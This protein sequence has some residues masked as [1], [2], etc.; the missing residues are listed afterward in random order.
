[1][2]QKL[3]THGLAGGTPL[4][5]P[6]IR[7]DERCGGTA[8]IHAGCAP[9]PCID[10]R[11]TR[12]GWP[13]PPPFGR[14]FPVRDGLSCATRKPPRAAGAFSSRRALGHSRLGAPRARAGRRG[15]GSQ[16]SCTHS[17]PSTMSV[18]PRALF[19]F[20]APCLQKKG[21]S[22]SEASCRG[23]RDSDRAFA[24]L[25]RSIC[26]RLARRVATLPSTPAAFRETAAAGAAARHTMLPPLPLRRLLHPPACCGAHG[27][28]AH[29]RSV[30][31]PRSLPRLRSPAP[32]HGMWYQRAPGPRCRL[33]L[34]D[35]CQSSNG[36]PF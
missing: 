19:A 31:L 4:P 29:T 22:T 34:L 25:R 21:I 17:Q 15:E 24:R 20:T 7:L 12:R 9:T 8:S 2:A 14:R 23:M 13:T 27:C 32:P 16:F 30:S 10:T 28:T 26:E 11:E 18:A 33:V 6:L 36:E 35:P 1:V 5:T 3:E